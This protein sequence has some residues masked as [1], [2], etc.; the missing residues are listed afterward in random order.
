MSTSPTQKAFKRLFR[1]RSAMFGMII[2]ILAVI[3]AFLGYLITP[4][5]TPNANDQILQISNKEPGFTIDI[6]KVK[7]NRDI[8]EHWFIHTMISGQENPY[9]LVPINGYEIVNDT[10]IVQEYAGSTTSSIER[11]FALADVVYALSP[12]GAALTTTGGQVSFNTYSGEKKTVSIAELQ[13]QTKAQIAPRTYQMGTD[14]FGRDMLSRLIIGVRIS[15]AVGLIAV[16]I[17]LAVGIFLGA[18]A[19]Y[20]SGKV[21]DAIMWLVNVVWDI[22]T[23]LLVFGITLALG[24][25]FWVVFIAIGIT[26][27]V[28]TARIVRGQVMTIKQQQFVEASQSMGFSDWRTIFIHILPNIMGPIIVISA[29]NFASAILIEAGLSYLGLGVDSITPTWGRMLAENYGYIISDSRSYL[30]LTPGFAIMIMVL[31][32]NLIGNGLRDALDIKTDLH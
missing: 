28:E 4:D 10:I 27:W 17:S 14:K 18:L 26:M 22:P 30:A 21:D 13:E 29:A 15:L 1:N 24:R 3:T 2:I 25:E 32:F 23:I 7:R 31:A 16:I 11:A 6:L 12:D 19:G 5:Q 8:P 20:Y 9:E